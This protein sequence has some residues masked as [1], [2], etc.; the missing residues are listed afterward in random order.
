MTAFGIVYGVVYLCAWLVLFERIRRV[1][2]VWLA[3]IC[4]LLC[5]AGLHYTLAL[6]G[7][8][9]MVAHQRL[10]RQREDSSK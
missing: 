1:L 7:H 5:V 8:L 3:L 9:C 10:K 4:G 6:V 2:P